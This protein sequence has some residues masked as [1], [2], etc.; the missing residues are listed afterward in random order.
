MTQEEL[1]LKSGISITSIRRYEA[2]KRMPSIAAMEK[3]SFAMGYPPSFIVVDGI[4]P[5]SEELEEMY[6][7]LDVK[8]PKPDITRL[9]EAYNELNS[10][11]KKK[12]IEYI[13][14]LAKLSEYR[15]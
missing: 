12:A 1:A 10:T 13:E 3:L 2:G 4:Y 8:P 11:G 9:N 15:L 5:T 6:K 7:N 14:D